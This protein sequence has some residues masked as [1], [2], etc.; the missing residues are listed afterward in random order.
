[1]EE[2]VKTVGGAREGAGAPL[3]NTNSSKSNRLFGDTIRRMVVQSEGEIARKV[4]EALILKAQEGDI[5]AIKEFADRVDGKSVATTEISGPDGS[6][7]R[8]GLPIEFVDA[9]TTDNT[10]SKET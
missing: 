5:A 4:A 6:P 1:M 3:G 2:Q 9:H 8:L 10:V 7:L